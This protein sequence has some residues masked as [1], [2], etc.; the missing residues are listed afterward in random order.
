MIENSARVVRVEGDIAWVRSESPSSCGACGGKGCG[1]STFARMLHPHEPEYAVSNPIDAEPGDNVVV[2]I[3]E[4][5]L[6]RAALSAYVVPL[7]LL[8]LGA[9]LGGNWGEGWAVAGG[10]AGLAVAALWL[11]RRHA[12]TAPVILR[13][14]SAGC[15]VA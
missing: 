5:S 14:G 3:E 12:A 13:R 2:G 4:G 8:L 11:K 1:S 9:L 6:L 15:S 10:V 7:L